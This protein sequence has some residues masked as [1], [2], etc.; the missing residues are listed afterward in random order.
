MNILAS[1]Q[2]ILI[3]DYKVA[4]EKLA[5]DAQL[6]DLGIDSLGRLELMFKIEDT[7]QVKIPGDP[8]SDL[9]TVRDVCAYIEGLVASQQG[10]KKP[11]PPPAAK[12]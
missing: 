4:R 6:S 11:A 10:P 8:P 2:E 5:P 7:F 3:K 9:V 12:S 1:L